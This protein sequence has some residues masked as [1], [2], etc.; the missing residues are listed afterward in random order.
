MSTKSEGGYKTDRRTASRDC[1]SLSLSIEEAWGFVNALAIKLEMCY[2]FI[3]IMYGHFM[4]YHHIY[5]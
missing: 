4:L 1:L 5:S 2:M 3:C